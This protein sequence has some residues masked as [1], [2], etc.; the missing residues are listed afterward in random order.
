MDRLRGQAFQ[1]ESNLACARRCAR[2]VREFL[3]ELS[4]DD[5][6]VQPGRFELADCAG[7]DDLAVAENR[8][9]IGDG[10]DFRH[11]VGDVDDGAALLAEVPDDV[12]QTVALGRREA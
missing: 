3:V 2:S 10:A 7:D 8:D 5:K 9:A 4:P 11:A 1:T 12:E 6:L